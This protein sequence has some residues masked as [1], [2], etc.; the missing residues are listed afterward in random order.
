MNL[1]LNVVWASAWLFVDSLP[2]GAIDKGYSRALRLMG[3]EIRRTDGGEA[4]WVFALLGVVVLALVLGARFYST[5]QLRQANRGRSKGAEKTRER[6]FAQR[7]A[8]LGLRKKEAHNLWKISARLSPKTPEALLATTSGVQCLKRDLAARIHKREKETE[9]LKSVLG[10]LEH[11]EGRSYHDRET[12]RVTVDLPIWLVKK[13]KAHAEF[14]HPGDPEVESF[15]VDQIHG[16]LQ[17]LSEGGAAIRVDL[18]L[19][20]GDLVEFGSA[21]SQIWLPPIHADVVGT[22]GHQE[23]ETGTTLSLT[24]LRFLNPPLTEIRRAVLEIQAFAQIDDDTTTD[25][26]VAA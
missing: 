17:D 7:A 8:E 22:E 12:L 2:A 25:E 18:P 20:D 14:S 16:Q 15:E 4:L 26:V 13:G 6:T 21:D 19:E 24:H 3:G 23:G 1:R 11:S 10:K 9:M 5:R